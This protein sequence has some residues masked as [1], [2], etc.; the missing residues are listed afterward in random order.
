MLSSPP[1]TVL[2]KPVGSPRKFLAA[3]VIITLFVWLFLIAFFG[4]VL[5]AIPVLVMVALFVLVSKNS[6]LAMMRW[7]QPTLEISSTSYAIGSTPTIVYSRKSKRVVDIVSCSVECLLVCEER[8][9]YTQGTDTTSVARRVY[10]SETVSPGQGTAE[11][12]V[13]VIELDISANRGSPSFKLRNNEVRWF[14]T[15][16]ASGPLLPRDSHTFPIEVA[17]VLDVRHRA[18]LQDT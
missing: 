13:A 4:I 9:T 15:V 12:L 2:C 18:G 1:G 11:G 6:L 3:F 10:E 5:A 8:V 17:L 14:L 7:N 16:S